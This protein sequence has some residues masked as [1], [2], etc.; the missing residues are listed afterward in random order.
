MENEKGLNTPTSL[1]SQKSIE[2][3]KARFLK[4]LTPV[5]ILGVIVLIAILKNDGILF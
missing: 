5:I 4:S 2:L 1:E 3:S